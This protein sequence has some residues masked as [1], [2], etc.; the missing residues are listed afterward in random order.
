MKEGDKLYL[1]GR[2]QERDLRAGRNL[3]AEQTLRAAEPSGVERP[4]SWTLCTR[5]RGQARP[6][7]SAAACREEAFILLLGT[8]LKHWKACVHVLFESFGQGSRV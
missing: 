4:C 6:D 2:G 1:E 5:G 3:Q 8:G 7:R